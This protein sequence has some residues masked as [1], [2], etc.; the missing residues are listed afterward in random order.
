MAAVAFQPFDNFRFTYQARFDENTL[1]VRGQEA[2]T[3]GQDSDANQVATFL[4]A[5]V[6]GI[7]G[8]AKTAQSVAV[9]QQ[10][11]EVLSQYLETLRP[12]G[13]PATQPTA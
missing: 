10:S 6:E 7:L 9:L 13:E 1:N 5:S 8:M 2:G 3:V 12:A 4:L 11:L